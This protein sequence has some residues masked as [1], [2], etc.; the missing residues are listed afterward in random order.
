MKV[1]IIAE[2]GINHNGSYEKALRMIDAVKDTSVNI[3][4]FQHYEPLKLLGAN[5]PYLTYAT[6]CQ[7]TKEQHERLQEYCTFLGLEYM[8]SVF[9]I[10][11]IPWADLL[12]KRH[13]VASRMNQDPKFFPALLQTGKEVIVSTQ[14]FNPPA[15]PHT[16]Y[17]YCITE[18]PTPVAKME[19]LPCNSNL[20]LSSHC[21]SIGPS[22]KA[23][24][25]GATLLEHHV[26]FDRNDEGC[27]HT[28]SITFEEL[29]QLQR[30][31]N[32]LEVIK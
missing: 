16:R 9:D 31:T 19:W 26:T 32:E 4:K 11:D 12:C 25:Q 5:S 15:M 22:L 29:R 21:P 23:V 3:V 17:M 6:K 2:L 20:G 27:D 28:S 14:S 24:A 7:F 10:K 1:D 30:T 13:K 18:Y 8:V